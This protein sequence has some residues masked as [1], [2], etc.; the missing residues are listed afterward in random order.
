[1][2]GANLHEGESQDVFLCIIFTSGIW[3][4]SDYAWDMF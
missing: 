1:M 4:Y 2:H 3:S